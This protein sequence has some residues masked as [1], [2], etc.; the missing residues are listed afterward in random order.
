M[1]EIK[2]EP[3]RNLK[4]CSMTIGST[5]DDF[6]SISPSKY[7]QRSFGSD[8]HLNLMWRKARFIAKEK[9]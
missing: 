5:G 9:C 1:I 6:F 2:Q 4:Y 7:T 3:R 8:F